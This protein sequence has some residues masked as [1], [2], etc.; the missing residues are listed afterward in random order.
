MASWLRQF[1]S[2]LENPATPL[3]FPAEWLLDIFNGGRTDSGIRVSELT[4]LSVS[5]VFSCVDI[6]S[7]LLAML[8]FNC[9]ERL[10]PSGKKVAIDQDL[11]WLLHDEPN[12]EMTSYTFRKT[13]QCHALLWTNAYGEI[14][15]N[16]FNQPV[17]I[18]PR[19]PH[20]TR[21]RRALEKFSWTTQ[22][23][24]LLTVDAGEMFYSTTEGVDPSSEVPERP[25]H[26]DDMIHILG[27]SLDGRLGKNVIDLSRQAIG[28]S[29]AA[30]KFGGKFFAN[31]LRPSGVITVPHTMRPEAKENF[32]RSLQEAYGGENTHRPIVID[33]GMKWEQASTT[34]NDAQ[35]LETRKFQRSEIAA[36]F[37]VPGYMV[38]DAEQ[39]NRANTEQLAIGLVNHTMRPWLEPWKQEFNRKIFPKR[40]R[41]ANKF[42]TDFDLQDLLL[43][44]SDS[45]GK[46]IA[47]LKQWGV[48]TT[49]DIRDMIG[50][51]PIGK[52]WAKEC[53]MPVNMVPASSPLP[54]ASPNEDA[55][56][57]P[58]NVDKEDERYARAYRPMFQ[59]VFSAIVARQN[60][61]LDHFS[62]SF[63]PVLTALSEGIAMNS[64]LFAGAEFNATPGDET[65]EFIQS[66][67]G[68]MHQRSAGWQA[69]AA[70]MEQELTRAVRAIKVVVYRDLATQAAK[71]KPVEVES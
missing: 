66:Y 53:W 37:H 58:A 54:A 67:V 43:P 23:G 12:E 50:W 14:E 2:S 65:A 15:R 36:V 8:P 63:L 5:T 52:E 64:A 57:K 68:G 6:V 56:K 13:M 62:R 11:Q 20:K 18:W 70:A 16:G 33:D 19:M 44:D 32:K 42:F 28:L 7:S 24:Q 47:L 4:A 34:P 17:A 59:S 22:Y 1:R 39:M 60:T 45:R 46:Y 27:L 35:F 30:E 10:T 21:P 26:R 71:A 51:N 29:L 38:G 41:T 55:P 9:Y 48:A 40:G 31:G 25:I 3:S 69:D 49:D 61:D